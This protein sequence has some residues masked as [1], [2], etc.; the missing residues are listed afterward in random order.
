MKL[1]QALV[2]LVDQRGGSDIHMIEGQP[3]SVRID[4]KL[5]AVP[6]NGEDI[7]VAREDIESVLDTLP[8]EQRKA[9]DHEWDVD[10]SVNFEKASGRVN[11]GMTNAGM[12][13][14]TMRYLRHDIPTIA[15]LGPA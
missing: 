12:L 8:L 4:G 7:I 11:I 10:F 15:E 1:L 13:S 2:H 3:A 14:L 6:K 5:V 9:F